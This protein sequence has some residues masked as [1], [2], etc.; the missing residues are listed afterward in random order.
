MSKNDFGVSWSTIQF[1]MKVLDSHKDYVVSYTREEDILFH[2]ELSRIAALFPNEHN[3][4]A[5]V[6]LAGGYITSEASVLEFHSVF[7]TAKFIVLGG[8][9]W[10]YTSEAHSAALTLGIKLMTLNEFLSA[11][12]SK[13]LAE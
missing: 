4:T 2:L 1:F 11:L 9:W 13:N 5:D 6:V 3:E 7:P 10:K 8:N 12:Y